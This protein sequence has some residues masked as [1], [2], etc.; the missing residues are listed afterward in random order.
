MG[1]SQGDTNRR[2]SQCGAEL[3]YIP[4]RRRLAACP[5]CGS[6]L[7]IASGSSVDRWLIRPALLRSDCHRL[8]SAWLWENYQ[9]SASGLEL[10]R[11]LWVPWLSRPGAAAGGKTGRRYSLAGGPDATYLEEL[12]LPPGEYQ[13]LAPGRAGGFEMMEG[14]PPGPDEELVYVP[15]FT[16]SFSYGGTRR[17]AVIEAST[18]RMAGYLPARRQRLWQK[19]GLLAGA[20][21]LFLMEAL[22]IP[23]LLARTIVLGLTFFVLEVVAGLVWEGWSWHK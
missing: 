20:G 15:C 6:R 21:T 8:L 12:G 16:A 3:G 4:A 7:Y 18:G 10:G 1:K 5:F 17:L 13:P 23:G 19:W 2:C 11:G 14:P 22:L 9:G